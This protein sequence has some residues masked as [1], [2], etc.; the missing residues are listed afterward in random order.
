MPLIAR[1]ERVRRP[2]LTV[3]AVT[4]AAEPGADSAG[5]ASGLRSATQGSCSLFARGVRAGSG[6]ANRRLRVDYGAAA[7]AAA[8][9]LRRRPG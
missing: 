4:C 8:E 9:G 3:C 6:G 1:R 7:V 5:A 2:I